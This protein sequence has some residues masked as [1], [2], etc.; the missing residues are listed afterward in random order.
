MFRRRASERDSFTGAQASDLFLEKGQAG[1]I[2]GPTV[3]DENYLRQK[4]EWV[5]CRL[6]SLDQMEAK[7]AEMRQLAE[8][9]RDN[10]LSKKK[11]NELNRKLNELQHE[12]MIELDDQSK[13]FKLDVQ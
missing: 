6:D 1:I 5:K 13:T 12:V 11:I 3:I 8:Y 10:T 7:L 9:A 2:K 4:L